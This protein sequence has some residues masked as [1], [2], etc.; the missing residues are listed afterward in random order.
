MVKRKLHYF[1]E[2][3]SEGQRQFAEW[4]TKTLAPFLNMLD[5]LGFTPGFISYFALSLLIPFVILYSFYPVI[6]CFFLWSYVILDGVDGALARHKHIDNA[7]GSLIDIVCDQ[8]GIM[9]CTGMIIQ[10][11]YSNHLIAYLY[12][13]SYII[14]IALNIA[15]NYLNLKVGFNFRTKFI[16]YIVFSLYALFPSIDIYNILLI[17]LSISIFLMTITN[18][19]SLRQLINFL[20]K[21]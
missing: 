18:I 19:I 16:I 17:I 7:G 11:D 15:Q 1:L 2:K 14:M 6:A 5:H 13:C 12:G 10:F 20:S 3:E 8:T 4:R 21:S 9:V